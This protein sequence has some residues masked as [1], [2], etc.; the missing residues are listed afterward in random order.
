MQCG[1]VK[2]IKARGPMVLIFL[3]EILALSER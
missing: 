1:I 2:E 3:K